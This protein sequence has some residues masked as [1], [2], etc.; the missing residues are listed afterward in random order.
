MLKLSTQALGE[1]LNVIHIQAGGPEF[2]APHP[3]RSLSYTASI[4][5]LRE[6]LIV[7]EASYIKRVALHGGAL[8]FGSLSWQCLTTLFIHAATQGSR[9]V[10][11]FRCNLCGAALIRPENGTF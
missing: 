10:K 3:S 1:F 11:V 5:R 8:L 4:R 7:D 6:S 9:T 2:R